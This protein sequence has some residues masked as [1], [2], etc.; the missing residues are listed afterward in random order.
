MTP[1]ESAAIPL[2]IARTPQRARDKIK[3]I[4]DL[5]AIASALK[6]RGKTIVLAHGVFDLVHMGHVRHLEAAAAEGDVLIVTITP[7]EF[8]NKGPGRPVFTGDLRAE[9][10]AALEC[11]SWIGINEW[12][13][14]EQ[15]LELIRPDVYVKGSD[16]SNEGED[17]TGKIRMEREAVER[18]GGRVLYT[19]DITFSSSSLINRHLNVFD[20]AVMEYLGGVD[21]EAQM[22]Q[23]LGAIDQIKDMRVLL[24]GEAIIDEYLYAKPMGKSAKENI[25]A[26]RYSGREVFAGGVIAAANHV[27]DFVKDVE[28]VTIL[29]ER[30]SYQS[31]IRDTIRDNV[32]IHSLYRPGLPTI[33]KSRYV[34]PGHMNKL[35][36]VYHFDDTPLNGAVE[37]QLCDMIGDRAKDF[38]VVIVADF[39]HGMMT[40][41]AIR[42]TTEKS[43]FLAV[44]AQSNS[45]NLGYNMVT[46]YNRADYVCIDAP[47]AQ[48]ATGDRFSDVE[49]VIANG[50]AHAI[51]CDRFVVTHGQHGCITYDRARG[52]RR[53]P[54]FTQQVVDTVGA[55]DA[56]L[57]VTSPVVAAG[58]D[59]EVAGF[60]GNA[61]GALKVGIVG[62]RQSVEK[63]PVQKYITTLLK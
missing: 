41:R 3:S 8:V 35:F 21:K 46:R 16:Y 9:M 29:G 58:T 59:M 23:A 14:A 15:L 54:A 2:D 51:D 17:L 53:V 7:D 31:L 22:E 42:T 50:L 27:A 6:A 4:R 5:A 37:K 19:D 25:I 47:E 1:R 43:R 45:A 60:I 56:F 30:E 10:L 48:L 32:T 13:S 63:V 38:D 57:S 49:D 40:P 28:V 61:V 52:T 12:P 34:D 20:P 26:S 24:V 18:H 62:H 36:E 44:N 11:T 39:G 55:G 33:R